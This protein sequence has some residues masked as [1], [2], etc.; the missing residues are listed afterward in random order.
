MAEI[1]KYLECGKIINTHGVRG[2]VKI[3]SWCDSLDVFCALPCIYVEKKSGLVKYEIESASKHKNCA[4]VKL[5]GVDDMDTAMLLKNKT[6]YADRE[7]IPVEEGAV[8][9][10]D[11]IGLDV[12]R[13]TNGEKLGV[14]VDIF[15]SVASDIYVI[16]TDD[17]REVMVPG[18]DEFIDEIDIDKG[19]TISPIPGMFED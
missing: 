10:A 8:F 16:K 13:S 1:Q 15:E 3:E 18:V 14:L 5:K 6:V 2:N 9:I 19:I 7:L 11:M 17:G 4:L 12:F